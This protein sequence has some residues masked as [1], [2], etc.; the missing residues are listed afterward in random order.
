MHVFISYSREDAQVAE[1]LNAA[2]SAAGFQT[3]YGRR[4]LPIGEEFNRKIAQA[5]SA[6][7][8]L[9]F[10]ASDCSIKLGSYTR[11]ELAFAESKWPNPNGFV[12]PVLINGCLAVNLPAYLRT[13][14]A[15]S[16]DNLDAQ[17]VAWVESRLE[18]GTSRPRDLLSQTDRLRRWAGNAQPPIKSVESKIPTSF[19]SYIF[20]ALFLVIFGIANFQFDAKWNA[21]NPPGSFLGPMPWYTNWSPVC[22]IGA[23]VMLIY[24]LAKLKEGLSTPKAVAVVILN[25]TEKQANRVDLETSV[26]CRLSLEPV[27][28]TA[29]KAYP[30]ELGWAYIS[31]T[32][33]LD[34][35]P[36]SA[37][38][39]EEPSS[40]KPFPQR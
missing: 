34:F 36:A 9:V 26:G 8:L 10:L 32:L 30:S 5:I 3:F 28:A 39:L 7:D 6:C 27:G 22:W 17:V 12:L 21:D 38:S 33:L 14:G 25:R 11:A 37:V 35:T 16:P 23:V 24:A 18:N 29:N 31:G 19:L 40:T 13:I 20:A 2:L 1:K 15:L 4:D